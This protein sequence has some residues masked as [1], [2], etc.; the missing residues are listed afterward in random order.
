MYNKCSCH[1]AS[2]IQMGTS[3]TNHVGDSKC[4]EVL[5]KKLG[6]GTVCT[7]LKHSILL[8]EYEL[9]KKSLEFVGK[10]TCSVINTAAFMSLS[11]SHD[12]IDVVVGLHTLSG[13]SERQLY[14]AC[15]KWARHQLLQLRNKDPSDEDIRDALGGALYKI[16]FPTMTLK[17][18]GEITTHSKI[19]SAEEKHDVYVY[20]ATGEK[21][22]TLKFLSHR[23]DQMDDRVIIRFN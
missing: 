7:F 20:M 8:D 9:R 3:V 21:L 10:Q 4:R 22:E 11:Q 17:A 19:L 23:R 5:K 13:T 1:G 14:E 6:M 16:R 12:G 18:F 15:V 2:L